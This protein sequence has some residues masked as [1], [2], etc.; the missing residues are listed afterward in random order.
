MFCFPYICT[1]NFFFYCS[2]VRR[3]TYYFPLSF[4]SP[5]QTPSGGEYAVIVADMNKGQGGVATEFIEVHESHKSGRFYVE[6][7]V[8]NRKA[9]KKAKKKGKVPIAKKSEHHETHVEHKHS[10][11]THSHDHHHEDNK[12]CSAG[13]AAS[14]AAR[15]AARAARRAARAAKKAARVARKHA[16][17]KLKA[18]LEAA[19]HLHAH[20]RDAAIQKAH[21]EHDAAVKAARDAVKAANKAAAEAKEH[22]IA[23]HKAAVAAALAAAKEKAQVAADVRAAQEKE[24][25]DKAQAAVHADASDHARAPHAPEPHDMVDGVVLRHGPTVHH[26][27]DC[28]VGAWGPWSACSLSCGKGI[29][30]RQ[31]TVKE[32]IDGGKACG[33]LVAKEMKN[34]FKECPVDCSLSDWSPLSA[35]SK[36]CGGGVQ[37]RTRKLIPAQFGGMC[38]P[39]LLNAPL[40]RTQDC[41]IEACVNQDCQLSAWSS[42]SECSATC[43]GGARVRAR[44]VV[45]NGPNGKPCTADTL[46]LPLKE[47]EPCATQSCPVDCS[48]S[49][50]SEFS[51][52]SATCGVGHRTR[53]RTIFPSQHGGH[54]C[55]STLLAKETVNCEAAKCPEDCVAGPWSHWSEC[56]KQ[57]GNGRQVRTRQI[58]PSKYGGKACASDLSVEFRACHLK[59]CPAAVDCSLSAWSSWSPCSLT[60][61]RGKQTRDRVMHPASNGGTPCAEETTHQEQP[62]NL[63]P[64]PTSD[65]GLLQMN[66][67]IRA[68]RKP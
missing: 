20:E 66:S 46:A 58:S 40:V 27:E 34:C 18:A 47:V 3:D 42:W 41:H 16:E 23:A 51:H 10:H 4:S 11:K 43:G 33:H 59:D 29:T 62:C 38:L 36:T 45:P 53:T 50:W 63:Q 35:C 7:L 6:D 19:K 39:E 12:H 21:D 64:C 61:G 8:K 60:C 17:E 44:A 9:I 5:A 1:S 52:C 56:D 28:E 26:P 48:V 49:E 55:P 14:A 67:R 2:F 65:H 32:A 37:V 31:R 25:L 30:T 15:K 57:C 13:N 22:A 68:I 24:R 54:A